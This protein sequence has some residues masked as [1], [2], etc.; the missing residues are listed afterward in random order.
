MSDAAAVP[1]TPATTVK[2]PKKKAAGA[3]KPKKQA[4]HP[5]YSSMIKDA[6]AALKVC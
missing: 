1:A 3:S 5:K 2:T 4:D 6:L